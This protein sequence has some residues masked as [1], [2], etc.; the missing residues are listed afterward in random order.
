[1]WSD[2]SEQPSSEQRS[3]KKMG[4]MSDVMKKLRATTH[5]TGEDYKCSRFKCFQNISSEEQQ[6]I[7]SNF[8]Q[9]GDYITQSQYLSGLVTV[10]PVQRRR[11]SKDESEASLNS[12]SYCY[13][14][15]ASVD[16]KLQDVSVCYK[17]FLS[18]H[19]VSNCRVQTIKKHLTEFGEARADGRRKHSNKPSKLPDETKSKVIDFIKSLKG[20]KS[21]YSLKDNS[22][23]YL[24]KELD[25]AK[26]QRM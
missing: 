1:M 10:V 26:F 8:N 13:C 5:E 6:R 24:P 11:N 17:A 21:L 18:L 15:R 3:V 9:L 16:G 2:F 22:R 19:G 7:I 12:S 25:V 14:V 23:V 20:R 4:K